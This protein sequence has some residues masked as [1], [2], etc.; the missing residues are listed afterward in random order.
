LL[1]FTLQYEMTYTNI[2]NILDLSKIP[3]FSKIG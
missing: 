2:L 1:G 3:I